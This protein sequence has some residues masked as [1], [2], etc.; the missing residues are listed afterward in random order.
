MSLTKNL[1][2]F[3]E[4]NKFC[5]LVKKL[6]L[7]LS[8]FP[9][10]WSKF[11]VVFDSAVNQACL[12]IQKIEEENISNKSRLSGIKKLFKKNYRSYFLHGELVKWSFKKP[13]GYPGDF[14]IIDDIYQNQPH[15]TGLNR[16]YDNHFLQLAASKATC[17]RKEDFKKGLFKF[18]EKHKNKEMRIMNLGSGSAREIKELL[19]KDYDKLFSRV[20]FDCYDFE[21]RAIDYAK[22]LL[23]NATNVNFFEKHTIRLA[24]AK[25][26][27]KEVYQQY[28]LIYSAGL[29]DYFEDKFA[30]RLVSNLRKL[31]K[32]EGIMMISNY[33]ER[34]N[35]PSACL[36]EWVSEWYLIY[37]TEDEFRRIFLDTGFSQ[38]DLQIISQKSK[39]MQYCF[40]TV[41]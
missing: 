2:I 36:M 1:N 24:F 18:V 34:S 39:V 28:D 5:E 21:I 19:E 3:S 4:V 26:I 27:K 13:F 25:N 6:Q 15:T 17:E 7:Y 9:D 35:N 22:K 41:R 37:R 32:K 31:L 20:T 12:E 29:F 8:K 38:K 11:Q 10:R 16:L 23:N 30:I 40:A 14:K 33:R